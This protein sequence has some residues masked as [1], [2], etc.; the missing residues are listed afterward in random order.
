[1]LISTSGCKGSGSPAQ[2]EGIALRWSRESS[3][4]ATGRKEDT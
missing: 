2:E 1:M 3:L 4:V